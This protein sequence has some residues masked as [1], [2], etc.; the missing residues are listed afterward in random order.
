VTGEFDVVVVGAGSAGCTQAGRLSEDPSLRVLL[1]A[2]G[3]DDA[4]EVRVP[5]AL[6]KVCARSAV[7]QPVEPCGPVPR[8]T[9]SVRAKGPAP[10]HSSQARS[11]PLER[12]RDGVLSQPWASAAA[13]GVGSTGRTVAAGGGVGV[14]RMEIDSTAAH[15]HS[16][17][18]PYQA[19]S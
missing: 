4:L 2:G 16:T 8:L 1:E 6:Y 10:P 19:P 12:A 7:P 14:R 17:A 3:S 5:A 15:T 11:G 18:A 13:A 9:P